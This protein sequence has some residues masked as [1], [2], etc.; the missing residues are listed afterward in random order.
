MVVQAENALLPV[1]GEWM[2]VRDLNSVGPDDDHVDAFVVRLEGDYWNRTSPTFFAQWSDLD[3][4]LPVQ[5]RDH[6]AVLGYLA[7]DQKTPVTYNTPEATIL[8]AWIHRI[9]AIEAPAEWYDEFRHDY[10]TSVVLEYEKR[11]VWGPEGMRADPDLYGMSGGGIWRFGPKLREATT[12]A[13]LSGIVIECH[14]KIRHKHI[15]GTRLDLIVGAL[16][17]HYPDVSAFIQRQVNSC[18]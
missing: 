14:F 17:Q 15:L 5:T 13:K 18:S 10:T 3:V 6:F 9:V 2:R 4:S 16:R 11:R 12:P 1:M 8:E 7:V